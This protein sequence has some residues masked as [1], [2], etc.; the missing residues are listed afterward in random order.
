MY[1]DVELDRCTTSFVNVVE[2]DELADKHSQI[3]IATTSQ[4]LVFFL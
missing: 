3:W 2:P 1:H 4:S